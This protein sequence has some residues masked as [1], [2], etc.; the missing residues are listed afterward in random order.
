MKRYQNARDIL[1]P[2]LLAA[3][4]QYAQ[5]LFLYIPKRPED[6]KHWGD[7]TSTRQLLERRNEALRAEHSEGIPLAML[8]ER[9][10]LSADT[11]RKIIYTKR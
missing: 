10:H 7:A 5:G 3:V 8:A 6:H 9:Y 1:P 11:I 4:Q 2:E